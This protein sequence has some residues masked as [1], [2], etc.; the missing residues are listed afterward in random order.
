[1]SRPTTTRFCVD[2]NHIALLQAD[3]LGWG[4]DLDCGCFR[5][6][7]ERPRRLLQRVV[8]ALRGRV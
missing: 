7:G 1:M 8:D 5:V 2:R 6:E 4:H 3:G